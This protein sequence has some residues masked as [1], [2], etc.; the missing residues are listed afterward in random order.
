MPKRTYQQYSSKQQN[1]LQSLGQDLNKMDIQDQQQ[2]KT[3]KN[4]KTTNDKNIDQRIKYHQ[5]RKKREKAV[6]SRIKQ[7]NDYINSLGQDPDSSKMQIQNQAPQN[8]TM[9]NKNNSRMVNDIEH[10]IDFHK[11]RINIERDELKRNKTQTQKN[12]KI[13]NNKN[14][15]QRIDYHQRRKKIEEAALIRKYEA[16]LRAQEQ[17]IKE[18]TQQISRQQKQQKLQKLQKQQKQKKQM[19]K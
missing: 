8:G 9:K 15:K 2:T 3:P 10:R 13:I 18:L 17:K 7:T 19:K 16:Q 6:L 1:L 5:Q 11:Q 4:K 12:K 14:I